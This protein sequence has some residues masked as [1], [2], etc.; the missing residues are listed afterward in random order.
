MPAQTHTETASTG[1]GF[2][3]SQKEVLGLLEDKTPATLVSVTGK[4]AGAYSKSKLKTQDSLAAE[5]V[6][7]LLLRETET[8]VRQTLAEH[9]KTSITVPRD[10]LMRLAQDVAEV[11][12]PV[13]QYSEVLTDKDLLDLIGNT[14]DV[15]RYLAISKRVVVSETVSGRLLDKIIPE[16]TTSLL[17]NNGADISEPHMLSIIAEHSDNSALMKTLSNRPHLPVNIVE[18]M[19]HVVSIH[20]GETLKQKYPLPSKDIELE[21]DKTR[22]SET[23]KL[24]RMSESLEEIDKL[25]NQL[26]AFNRLTPSLILSGLCQG[27]FLFFETS[28]ARLS[29]I[30]VANARTLIKDR[31]DLGFRA[32]YNKSGLPESLFPAVRVLLKVIH[33]LDEKGEKPTSA[34]YANHVIEDILQQSASQ[35]IDNLSYIVA[36]VRRAAH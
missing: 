13:L 20:M 21:I 15:N 23:L 25:V 3:L 9:I 34:R 26:I 12:L 14:Q 35:P 5:Q 1:Y 32:I 19:L 27:N 24:I 36:L 22:E 18:K 33:K 4:I 10:I 31:G 29:N 7:R 16:V 17:H 28:L 30:P 11:S 2:A 6:F 8:N